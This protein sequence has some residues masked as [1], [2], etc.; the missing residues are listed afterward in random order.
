MRNVAATKQPPLAKQ[1]AGKR[2]GRCFVKVQ[3]RRLANGSQRSKPQ[4]ENRKGVCGNGRAATPLPNSKSPPYANGLDRCRSK[5][6]PRYA[7][8]RPLIF[9]PFLKNEFNIQMN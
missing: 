9:N 7:Y 5:A 6:L 4:G 3:R 2:I 1:R 8:L